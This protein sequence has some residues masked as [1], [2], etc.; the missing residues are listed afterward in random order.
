MLVQSCVSPPHHSP[1]ESVYV[2]GLEGELKSS[3]PHETT[4]S[5]DVDSIGENKSADSCSRR[6][7]ELDA[8]CVCACAVYFDD[9]LLTVWRHGWQRRGRSFIDVLEETTDH[10][11]IYK[12]VQ[13]DR[14]ADPAGCREAARHAVTVKVCTLC[15]IWVWIR[16]WFIQQYTV[17]TIKET[18]IRCLHGAA[19]RPEQPQYLMLHGIQRGLCAA[20]SRIMLE[21]ET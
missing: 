5:H 15:V 4:F 12:L 8:D 2:V 16:M 9:T 14:Y 11:K 13:S 21:L 3:R 6:R 1:T 17:H 7:L 20:M 10:R 18:R 19:L